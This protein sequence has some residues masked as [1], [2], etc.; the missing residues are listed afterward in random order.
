MSDA[1][2]CLSVMQPMFLLFPK[3]TLNAILE[4]I[5]PVFTQVFPRHTM[6]GTEHLP[7]FGCH[8]RN[9]TGPSYPERARGAF[10][11]VPWCGSARKRNKNK[12]IKIPVG[13]WKSFSFKKVP[14]KNDRLDKA[15]HIDNGRDGPTDHGEAS[16]CFC[17]DGG[18]RKRRRRRSCG[19]CLRMMCAAADSHMVC[20]NGW[21]CD[22][23]FFYSFLKEPIKNL[24]SIPLMQQQRHHNL[25]LRPKKRLSQSPKKP[26]D[27]PP[28]PDPSEIFRISASNPPTSSQHQHPMDD[29]EFGVRSMDDLTEYSSDWGRSDTLPGRQD[30]E[31]DAHDDRAKAEEDEDMDNETAIVNADEVKRAERLET[32]TENSDITSLQVLSMQSSPN[33]GSDNDDGTSSSAAQPSL[34]SLRSFLKDPLPSDDPLALAAAFAAV[35]NYPQHPSS[36]PVRIPFQRSVPQTP[37]FTPTLSKQPSTASTIDLDLQPGSPRSYLSGPFS[38]EISRG[39][40][41]GTGAQTPA[42]AMY[43]S[44]ADLVMPTVTVSRRRAPTPRGQDVGHFKVLIAGDSGE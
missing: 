27:P 3:I 5:L 26:S 11:V 39:E 28:D 7:Q 9:S 40:A 37:I 21:F 6:I 34:P 32:I 35:N 22:R 4:R 30:V 23:A 19:A 41:G 16:E 33:I 43:D 1:L 2:C 12:S 31:V 38:D 18:V 44:A 36:H 42:A 13:S 8:S 24:C 15:E 10:M 25:L 29:E 17:P 14:T 20:A